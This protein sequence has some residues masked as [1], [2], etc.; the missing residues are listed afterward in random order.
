MVKSR[1]YTQTWSQFESMQK[2]QKKKSTNKIEIY[3][4]PKT[5][6]NSN[7]QLKWGQKQ[8]RHI[9]FVYDIDGEFG[10]WK[11]LVEHW[12]IEWFK[13]RIEKWWLS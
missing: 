11:M 7:S 2:K 9:C 4:L 10:S 5:V 8:T 12:M 3:I 1:E 6:S 13:T